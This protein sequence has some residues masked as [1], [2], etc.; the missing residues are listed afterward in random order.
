MLED[1]EESLQTITE[2]RRGD[3]YALYNEREYV[4]LKAKKV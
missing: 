4:K 3:R 2:N 1:N